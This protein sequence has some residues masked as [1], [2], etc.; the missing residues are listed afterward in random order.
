MKKG[1]LIISI[2]LLTNA[3]VFSQEHSSGAIE[4]TPNVGYTTSSVIGEDSP[5]TDPRRSYQV[6]IIGDY[7][8]NGRWSIRTGISKYNIGAESFG[9]DLNLSYINIPINAN[10]HFGRTR[11]WNL[12]FGV[13]SGFLM[14]A[15]IDGRNVQAD[16]KSFHLGL[17]YGIGY[18][19]KITEKV[20][21]LIDLQT[22][23]GLTPIL[24]SNRLLWLNTVSGF[25]IGW[26]FLF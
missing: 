13:S 24:E 21:I 22:L 25:N 1:F 15:N 6:S 9:S 4:I 19:I 7:Y 12:N 23:A 14:S 16:Y 26:V 18:K 10:W 2:I 8:F 3:T 20:R 11:K 5:E 17:Y